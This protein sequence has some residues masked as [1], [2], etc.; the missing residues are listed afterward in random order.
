MEKIKNLEGISL[1]TIFHAWSDAFSNYDFTWTQPELERTLYR[2]GYVPGLSFGAF[3]GE[4][5]IS[6]ILNG[7]GTFNGIKTAYDTGTGT[8]KAYRGCG[9]VEKTFKESEPLLKKAG[10]SQYLLEVLTHNTAAIAV[11]SKIGLKVN[12]E[13]NYFRQTND[14]LELNPKTL[15][16]GYYLKETDLHEMDRMIS[17]WDFYPAWQNSFESVQRDVDS[18]KIIGVFDAERLM[19]YG[20]TE[21]ASGD[22]TQ[23][24]VDKDYRRRGIGSAILKELIKHNRHHSVKIVNTD[25]NSPHVVMFI[26]NNGIPKLGTQYEMIKMLK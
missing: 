1:N 15:P 9:L 13:L 25:V 4:K 23:L 7:I 5:L 3:D 24:A 6:F 2:R 11:Y 10:I 14:A 16:A 19:G 20:I 12:R 26:E 22:I 21:P 17:M 8:I 18:L